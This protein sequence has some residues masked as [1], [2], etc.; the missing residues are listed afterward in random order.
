MRSPVE[1]IDVSSGIQSFIAQPSYD[2]AYY[3]LPTN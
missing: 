2:L 1:S 3:V